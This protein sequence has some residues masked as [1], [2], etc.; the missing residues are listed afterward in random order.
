MLFEKNDLFL[1]L[2]QEFLDAVGEAL[3]SVHFAAGQEIFR[4]GD[5]SEHLYMLDDGRVRLTVGKYGSVTKIVNCPGDA[6]GWSSL[7]GEGAYTATAHC[8]TNVRVLRISGNKMESLLE[9]A[10]SSGLQFYRRLARLIRERLTESHR[11]LLSYDSE[12]KPQSY[13]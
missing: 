8:L 1:G 13:G 7:I 4:E 11:I 5:P 9:E 10:P 2:S 6:F 12:H 3:E